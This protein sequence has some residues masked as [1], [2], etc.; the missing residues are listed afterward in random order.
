M[1][2][3]L[4]GKTNTRHSSDDDDITVDKNKIPNDNIGCKKEIDVLK[5]ESKLSLDEVLEKKPKVCL[6]TSKNEVDEEVCFYF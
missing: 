4:L 1:L 5:H 6:E 3:Y 2:F